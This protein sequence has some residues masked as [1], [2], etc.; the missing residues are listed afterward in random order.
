MS[1]GG[2]GAL[3]PARRAALTA[4]LA[5]RLADQ[6][7]YGDKGRPI[8]AVELDDLAVAAAD[9]GIALAVVRV[10]FAAGDD[11]RYLLPIGYVDGEAASPGVVPPAGAASPMIVDALTLPRFPRWLL[12]RI[13]AGADMPSEHG[14]VRWEAL[15]GA[16]DCLARASVAP[17]VVLAAE[18]SN[19]AIRYGDALIVKLFRRLRDGVNPDVEVGRFL[20]RQTDFRNVPAPI[21]T[22]SYLPEAGG[23]FEI[24]FGQAFAPNEGDGWTWTSRQIAAMLALEAAE[25]DAAIRRYAQAAAV[26][27]QRTAA[28]HRALASRPDD[29]AFAPEPLTPERIRGWEDDLRQRLD[30]ALNELAADSA[31]PPAVAAMLPT[32][33]RQR[34]ALA[35][36]AAGFAAEA[37]DVAIRVH[38]DFHLGQA[39]RTGD[40]WT[41]LD[42]EGEPARPLAERRSRRG[43]RRRGRPSSPPIAA[44]SRRPR[45]RSCRPTPRRSAALATPGSW[46]R[47]SMRSPTS[48][49][50]DPIGW[51]FP[52][53]RCCA[54]R[55][56]AGLTTEFTLGFSAGRGGTPAT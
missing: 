49:A 31:L 30:A 2:I 25:R 39:L 10:R 11:S 9:P 55:D 53:R 46:T 19:S 3:P 28:L 51:R 7:W 5:M 54:R 37:G 8:A 41:L 27:G 47:R 34:P 40:D 35:T 45:P 16:A 17:A 48:G 23:Q 43:K 38:G 42:F 13:A 6:R 20:W 26:L 24:A 33:L 18:Q 36:R 14:R 22:A 56:R 1:D 29:P 50:I 32:L 4:A 52:W 12:D 15:P 44:R 21:A